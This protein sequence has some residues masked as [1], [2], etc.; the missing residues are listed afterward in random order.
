M[1]LKKITVPSLESLA[2]YQVLLS[3]HWSKILKV[4]HLAFLK[5]RQESE[6]KGRCTCSKVTHD[7][8]IVSD[9]GAPYHSFV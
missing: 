9:P 8:P 4:L 5:L 2:D 1:R 3:Q 6:I 7:S